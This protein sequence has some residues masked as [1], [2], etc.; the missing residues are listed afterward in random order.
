MQHTRILSTIAMLGL[1]LSLNYTKAQSVNSE[2]ANGL[3]QPTVQAATDFM[4][5]V[6]NNPEDRIFVE[7]FDVLPSATELW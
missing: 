5:Q 3:Y 7:K 6:L 1:V 2:R 4:N